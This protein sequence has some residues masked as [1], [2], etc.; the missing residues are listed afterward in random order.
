MIVIAALL[1]EETRGAHARTDFPKHAI[2]AER[3]TLRLSDALD[4]AQNYIPDL[5]S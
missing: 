2:R 4:A 1:R 5:V 3:S